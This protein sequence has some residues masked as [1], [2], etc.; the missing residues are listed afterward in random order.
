MVTGVILRSHAGGYLVYHPQYDQTFFCQARGR[1]KKE[2]VSILTGDLVELEDLSREQETAVIVKCLERSSLLSRPQ[3][4]NVDQVVIVQ[5]VKQ[6]EWNQLWCDR[7]I[8]HFQLELPQSVPILCFNKCDL[9]DEEKA[10][11]LRDIYE[12]L[13][14]QV[15]MVSAKTQ[16]GIQG[17]I[18]L[19]KGKITVFAGPSGVG[20][21]SLLNSIEPSLNLKIGVMDSDV[22]VGRH[23]TTYSEIYQVHISKETDQNYDIENS[24][25]ALQKSNLTW[26]A[27]TPGFNLAELRHPEP[28]DLMWE[29]PEI[30]SLAP[31]CKFSNCLHLVETDCNVIAKYCRG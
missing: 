8:V 11:R 26:V 22:G 14:Y 16:S 2:K 10:N 27:D 20:K 17:L 7:Y 29:F 24:L 18:D 5:A 28:H 4:A 1:L 31:E 25:E 13:N 6:P 21:S 19:L 9:L 23:T 15:V 12:S 30:K 3:I